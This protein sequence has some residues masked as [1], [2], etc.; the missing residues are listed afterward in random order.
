MGPCRAV[1]LDTASCWGGLTPALWCQDCLGGGAKVLMVVTVSPQAAS[2]SQSLCSLQFAS[3]VRGM[4]LGQATRNVSA[5]ADIAALQAELAAQAQ[6]VLAHW[7]PGPVCTRLGA[8]GMSLECCASML[9]SFGPRYEDA[10]AGM[11]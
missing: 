1:K 4:T 3:R 8:T 6:Q 11:H 7:L 2:A 9:T 10:C 5:G